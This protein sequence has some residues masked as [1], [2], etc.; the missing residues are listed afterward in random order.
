MR[1]RNVE[2]WKVLC[3]EQEGGVGAATARTEKA[4]E[5]EVWQITNQGNAEKNLGDEGKARKGFTRRRTPTR[6]KKRFAAIW[7]QMQK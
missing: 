5:D 3:V 6:G 2:S 4:S 1:E 7:T